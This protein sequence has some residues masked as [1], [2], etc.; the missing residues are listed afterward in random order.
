MKETLKLMLVEFFIILSGTTICAAIFCTMFNR[1]VTLGL[2][3]LWQLI[4]LAFLTTMPQL[5]F[6][7][8]REIPKKQMRIRQTIHVAL[9][10]GLLI[11][12]AYTWG[13]IEFTTVLQPL[14]FIVLVLLSYTGITMFMYRR[15]KK[16]AVMLTAKLQKYKTE[17]EE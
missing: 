12:L 5:L 13:W 16:L 7:S 11:F 3:F 8:K 17:K 6:Y 4:A 14:A 10:V 9:V 15:E 1:D 2:D